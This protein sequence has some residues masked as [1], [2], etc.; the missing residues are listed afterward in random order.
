MYSNPYQAHQKKNVGLSKKGVKWG[1]I[2]R[3]HFSKITNYSSP[4]HGAR[5]GQNQ[6]GGYITHY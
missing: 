2:A 3:G 5:H 6:Y 1:E 4:S